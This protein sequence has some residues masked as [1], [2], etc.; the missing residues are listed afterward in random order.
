M[1]FKK[2]RPKKINPIAQKLRAIIHSSDLTYE[3]IAVAADL[4]YNTFMNVFTR[5]KVSYMTL[6][7][8]QQCGLIDA[9]DVKEYRAWL[10]A[11]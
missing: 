2:G 9:G 1:P 6:K 4:R 5:D 7:S 11:K 8:L 10:E 3:K